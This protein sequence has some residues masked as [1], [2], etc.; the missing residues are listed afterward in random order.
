[1]ALAIS[2]DGQRVQGLLQAAIS[3]NNY[4]SADSFSLTFAMGAPPLADFAWWSQLSPGYVEVNAEGDRLPGI[5]RLITGN[6]DMLAVDPIMG[7]VSVE[8]RDLSA[9]LI[10]TY[11]QQDFVNQTASEVISTLC[12]SH[13]LEMQVTSTQGNI[14]RYFEDGFTKLSLGQFSHVRS[15]WDLVVQ[16]ARENGFDVFMDGAT[17]T[18]QPTG[19]VVTDL[20][21][22]SPS[23][24]IKMRLEQNLAI[25]DL[26]TIDLQSWNSQQA[27][28]YSSFDS[29]GQ[30]AQP[31]VTEGA[32]STYLFSGSNLTS[33][34]ADSRTGQYLREVSRLRTQ[35][36]L[37]VPW[38][39]NV[40]P[41]T[42][43]SLYTGSAFDGPYQ[44]DSVERFYSSAAGST[45]MVRAVSVGSSD[46]QNSL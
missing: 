8:G 36:H 45:Q 26:P 1:M 43:L 35:L 30:F 42:L 19:S 31:T 9:R 34:Q 3:N 22:I 46:N 21:E 38:N 28:V 5:L 44:V 4:F 25:P 18:F 37:E 24:V 41:R 33:A 17:L 14:G 32:S 16:L 23:S 15:N 10:D 27:K 7:M 39:F 29:T 2:I 40:F 13:G 20:I 12:S 11:V 6:I